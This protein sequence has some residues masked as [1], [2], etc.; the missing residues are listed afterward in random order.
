[1]PSDEEITRHHDDDHPDSD[2]WVEGYTQTAYE[3]RVVD[4]MSGTRSNPIAV[5]GPEIFRSAASPSAWP[6]SYEI[7][8]GSARRRRESYVGEWLPEPLVEEYGEEELAS[9]A[10]KVSTVL[11]AGHDVYCYFKHEGGGV[12]P[13]YAL[14]VEQA[15]GART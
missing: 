3:I 15:A 14:A 6:G 2:A 13:A 10:S 1:M 8:L 9:W 4:P 11:D 7:D 12:G 5:E